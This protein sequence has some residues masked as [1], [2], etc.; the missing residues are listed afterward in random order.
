MRK[1]IGFLIILFGLSQFFSTSVAALNG[2][3]T[4]SFHTLEA[5][6]LVAQQHITVE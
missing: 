1:A 6:A 5:A 4:E 2:A 3:L